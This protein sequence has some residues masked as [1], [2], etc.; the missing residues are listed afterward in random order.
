M[1]TTKRDHPRPDDA[2]DRATFMNGI[3]LI[4]VLVLFL[5]GLA[6]LWANGYTFNPY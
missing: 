1:K 5:V 6:V 3:V 2:D 4:I